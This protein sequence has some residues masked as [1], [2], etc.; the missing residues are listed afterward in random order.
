MCEHMQIYM[1]VFLHNT[2]THARRAH[3]KTG[4]GIESY[5]S[6]VPKLSL[7]LNKLLLCYAYRCRFKVTRT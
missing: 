3:R 7:R 5:I 4:A 2:H 6:Y 1:H